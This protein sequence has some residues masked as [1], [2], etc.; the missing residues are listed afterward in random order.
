[1]N[2]FAYD[3]TGYGKSQGKCS[4]AACYTDMDTAFE[5]LVED[6]QIPPEQIVL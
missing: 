3:Y 5:Y 4:E 6:Q 2:V 1:M